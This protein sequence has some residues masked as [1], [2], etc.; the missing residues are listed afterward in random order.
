MK[1][2]RETFMDIAIG[3]MWIAIAVIV[4]FLLCFPKMINERIYYGIMEAIVTVKI[5]DKLLYWACGKIDEFE[6][7]KKK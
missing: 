6:R 1:L 2:K 4:S 5:V 7:S 3:L